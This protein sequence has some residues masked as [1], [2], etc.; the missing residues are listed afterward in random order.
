MR[1][2]LN[3]EHNFL[4]LFPLSLV[5]S[6]IVHCASNLQSTY[7]FLS[8]IREQPRILCRNNSKQ[9]FSSIWFETDYVFLGVLIRRLK[10][11]MKSKACCC[12]THTYS[13]EKRLAFLV[14]E[15]DRCE[16]DERVQTMKAI[17]SPFPVL[18][19]SIVFLSTILAIRHRFYITLF[20][21]YCFTSTARLI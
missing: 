17:E 13:G 4:H 9:C 15:R 2:V 18:A 11:R 7:P 3:L 10:R 21:S 20:I 19:R 1:P 8:N 12:K 14:R 16:K 5:C 6:H